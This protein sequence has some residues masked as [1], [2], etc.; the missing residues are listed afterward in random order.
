MTT[1]VA[2][3]RQGEKLMQTK[4]FK[5]LGAKSLSR[6]HPECG[7]HGLGTNTYWEC[8]LRHNTYSLYNPVGTCKMGA[9]TDS[10]AV[11]DT[12]LR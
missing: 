9:K 4:M 12:Q 8:F 6:V 5:T 11:V 7:E 1:D 3:I 2:G 10:S